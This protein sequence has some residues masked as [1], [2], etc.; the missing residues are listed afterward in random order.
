MALWS[1]TPAF[2]RGFGPSGAR[3]LEEAGEKGEGRAGGGCRSRVAEPE[4]LLDE[5]PDDSYLPRRPFPPL[6][7]PLDVWDRPAWEKVTKRWEP[8][9]D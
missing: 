2:P 9:W 6:A 3:D 1:Q 4:L 7:H 5:S 8:V